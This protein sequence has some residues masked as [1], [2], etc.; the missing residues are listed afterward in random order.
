MRDPLD[1][2]AVQALTDRFTCAVL[3]GSKVGAHYVEALA[4]VSGALTRPGM[5]D[6]QRVDAV[7]TVLAAFGQVNAGSETPDGDTAEQVNAARAREKCPYCMTGLEA[8]CPWHQSSG[9]D[10]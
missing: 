7:R 4:A 3:G 10:I 2:A 8:Q 6:T 9:G 5:D 1:P